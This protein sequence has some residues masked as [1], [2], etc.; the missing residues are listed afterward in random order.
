MIKAI[1]TRYKGYHFR[2]RLEARWA[3]FFDALGLEWEYEP[4]GFDLGEAGWYL[5]DFKVEGR[6]IEIKRKSAFEPAMKPKKVY[7]AGKIS[8]GVDS[9]STTWRDDLATCSEDT[10]TEYCYSGPSFKDTSQGRYFRDGFNYIGPFFTCN[11]GTPSCHERAVHQIDNCDFLFAWI[12]END[13]YGT[14]C[15]I[16]YAST[17]GKKVY[18]AFGENC[19]ARDHWFVAKF[20]T[21]TVGDKMVRDGYKFKRQIVQSVSE[22]WEILVPRV[23]DAA[24]KDEMKVAALSRHAPVDLI[25]GDPLDCVSYSYENGYTDGVVRLPVVP[26]VGPREYA[27]AAQKARSARF[28][29]GETPR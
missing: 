25:M 1:Q 26:P 18:V 11:H 20:A 23:K 14:I 8:S 19:D 4:E 16:V 27:M 29:H 5:P 12:D 2:S 10:L 28:E 21:A 24:D 13:S 6:Y 3:V 9:F 22:A 15:E 7:L 17:I